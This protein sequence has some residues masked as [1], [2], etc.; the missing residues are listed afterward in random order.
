M[1][2]FILIFF[3]LIIIPFPIFISCEYSNKLYLYIFFIK[4]NISKLKLLQN[5]NKQNEKTSDKNKSIK[6]LYNL[7]IRLK[8]N[9]LK[10]KIIINF[11]M[12]YGFDDAA[13]VALLYGFFYSISPL[14]YGLFN[15]TFD[16]KKY[17]YNILA[18]TNKKILNIK[19][20]SII[21][22]NL[23]K[24]INML[25]IIFSKSNYNEKS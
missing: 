18:Y 20:K 3:I 9:K 16:V 4:I 5:K 17:N 25:I 11:E 14:L 7:F 6:K 24:I 22:I 13:K 1:F 8:K 15:T 2:W 23:V 21:I 12:N 10:S 19:F